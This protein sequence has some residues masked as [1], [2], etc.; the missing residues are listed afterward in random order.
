MRRA[1]RAKTTGEC[2]EPLTCAEQTHQQHSKVVAELSDSNRELADSLAESVHPPTGGMDGQAPQLHGSAPA[3]LPQNIK[4]IAP[5]LTNQSV[6]LNQF[7][8]IAHRIS[9]RELQM[10]LATWKDSLSRLR[11]SQLFNL[12]SQ[13]DS[14]EI[15]TSRL[16]WR[17]AARKG[18]A[19]VDGLQMRQFE[20]ESEIAELRSTH[21]SEI[22]ELKRKLS[23]SLAELFEAQMS[24][25]NEA[26]RHG[27]VVQLHERAIQQLVEQ[28]EL[29]KQECNEQMV[30]IQ[31][32]SCEVCAMQHSASQLESQSWEVKEA[33]ADRSTSDLQDV[34][35]QVTTVA[36]QS[37]EG[38]DSSKGDC[39]QCSLPV[40]EHQRRLKGVGGYVHHD[41]GLLEK[42]LNAPELEKHLRVV[43]TLQ[44]RIIELEEVVATLG[45]TAIR[46]VERWE[47][48]LQHRTALHYDLIAIH[49]DL[50]TQTGLMKA[51]LEQNK[52]VLKLS[53]TA[54][55]EALETIAAQAVQLND[56]YEYHVTLL[57]GEVKERDEVIRD[58]AAA[59]KRAVTAAEQRAA[60][61]AEA[62]I[63]AVERAA[64]EKAVVQAE[65][66]AEA[67]A[68]ATATAAAAEVKAAAATAAAAAVM[69]A[70]TEAR[71]VLEADAAAAAVRV[72]GETTAVEAK[73]HNGSSGVSAKG[74]HETAATLM[75]KGMQSNSTDPPASTRNLNVALAAVE[76]DTTGSVAR[77][78]QAGPIHAP[79]VVE[80]TIESEEHAAIRRRDRKRQMRGRKNNYKD[81]ED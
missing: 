48:E 64:E 51:H 71:S 45:T 38:D 43:S 21:Q 6:A 34:I 12:K 52:Q 75:E 76:E 72:V 61:K 22:K 28:H 27:E 40:Q 14:G 81:F 78:G 19:I 42:K 62:A 44:V 4:S 79:L 25:M 77:M 55:Q 10:R 16:S 67:V 37:K 56:I 31:L 46:Q 33:A 66:A 39:S 47:G 32:S 3:Q 11:I 59:N 23:D 18:R 60:M 69:D 26:V 58:N 9:Q 65:A 17:E 74:G 8:Y 41:C 5:A 63:A 35:H 54:S 13:R 68:A 30:A 73:D 29:E 2:R 70:A 24:Q 49:S 36:S 20:L 7:K 53:K 80:P 1:V 50:S 15:Q 57:K